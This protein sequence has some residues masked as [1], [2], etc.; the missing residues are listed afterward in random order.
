VIDNQDFD[1]FLVDRE[2]KDLNLSILGE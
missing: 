2:Y 1:Q